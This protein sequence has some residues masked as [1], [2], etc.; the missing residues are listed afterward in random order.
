M[1]ASPIHCG[2]MMRVWVI[3]DLSHEPAT[4]VLRHL[5]PGG[6]GTGFAGPQAQRP[7]WGATRAAAGD[8]AISVAAAKVFTRLELVH[9]AAIGT[10]GLAG[11][12]HVQIDA[13]WLFHSAIS[14]WGLGLDHAALGIEVAGQQLDGG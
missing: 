7:L 1:T 13:G 9:R 14:A 10:L 5:Y 6:R 2:A 4:S 3:Q 12:R 8:G 11:A